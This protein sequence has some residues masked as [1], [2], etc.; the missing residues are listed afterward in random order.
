MSTNI[1]MA[2]L[3]AKAKQDAIVKA[4]KTKS[5]VMAIGKTFFKA[6][7][8]SFRKILTGYNPQNKADPQTTEEYGA[9]RLTETAMIDAA[10]AAWNFPDIML[11]PVPLTQVQMSEVAT[12]QD[13]LKYRAVGG[14]FLAHQ[15]G[16][17]YAMRIDAKL[18]GQYAMV[19]LSLLEALAKTGEVQDILTPGLRE[20]HLTMNQV[21]VGDKPKRYAFASGRNNETGI[22]ERF[23]SPG[24]YSWMKSTWHKTFPIATRSEILFD[25]YIESI[26]YWRSNDKD[27]NTINITILCRK[28]IP[29]PRIEGVFLWNYKQS[30]ITPTDAK[31][32]NPS[33]PKIA[34]KDQKLS[35]RTERFLMKG[36]T[37][38]MTRV[39]RTSDI[40]PIKSDWYDLIINQIHRTFVSPSRFVT[41]YENL[42]TRSIRDAGIYKYL[43]DLTTNTGRILDVVG[44]GV[45]SGLLNRRGMGENGEDYIQAEVIGQSRVVR[46]TRFTSDE[47]SI[48]IV[49][50]DR[51][52][53]C[54][55]Y[56]GFRF[57]FNET[58]T[59]KMGIGD[60]DDYKSKETDE[61]DIFTGKFY[62]IQKNTY[63]VLISNKI[64]RY[65]VIYCEDT[66]ATIKRY[67]GFL[68]EVL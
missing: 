37:D 48:G 40:Y 27:H 54:L 10:W 44:D 29:P 28:F 42:K 5:T 12:S 35:Y 2:Q 3:A 1:S 6:L 13:V 22:T 38:K 17:S 67:K 64:D 51:K 32:L 36:F 68:T 31:L 8:S 59:L 23:V 15:K 34:Y 11:G 61:A 47:Q 62:Y 24:D 20:G 30:T 39:V 60:S 16:G 9:M 63:Y 14:Q 4:K 52:F 26:I 33:D 50:S 65:L 55:T 53:N 7:P 66:T 49:R 21:P 43:Y 56:D 25:M 45:T 58:G 57:C 18:D 46:M 41:K 19:F